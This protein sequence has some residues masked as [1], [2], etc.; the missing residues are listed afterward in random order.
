MAHRYSHRIESIPLPRVRHN[1]VPDPAFAGD[2]ISVTR[3]SSLPP[4]D[5]GSGEILLEFSE[6]RNGDTNYGRD[7]DAAED[8]AR[9]LEESVLGN[10]ATPR[11]ENRKR[12]APV[13][14]E[15]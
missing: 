7:Y 4:E 11:R 14:S 10:G 6:Y 13:L 5:G 12:G 1:Y 15:E 9:E 8:A 2:S 3:N